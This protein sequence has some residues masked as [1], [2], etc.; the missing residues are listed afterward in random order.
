MVTF[1]FTIQSRAQL[2]DYSA[3]IDTLLTKEIESG[4]MWWKQIIKN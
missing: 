1:Y 2:G 3:M 4:F